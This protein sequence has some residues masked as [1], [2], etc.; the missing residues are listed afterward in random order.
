[1]N[2]CVLSFMLS[3]DFIR[4]EFPFYSAMREHCFPSCLHVLVI[5]SCD[6]VCVFKCVSRYDLVLGGRSRFRL[7]ATVYMVRDK[8][9]D[10]PPGTA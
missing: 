4:G 5:Y 9:A 10:V 1:V 8:F 3:C 2:L 7:C 6:F